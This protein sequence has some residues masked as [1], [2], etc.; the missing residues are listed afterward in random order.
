M[1][2]AP[3]SQRL[4]PPARFAR[5]RLVLHLLRGMLVLRTVYRR[6][7]AAG[8]QAH[9]QAWSQRLLAL[10]GV[11]LRVHTRG[12]VLTSGALV[13]SNHVSWLDIQVIDAWRPTPF[14]AKAEIEGWPLVGWL[15]KSAGT[16]FIRRE[17][18]SDARRV[19]EQLAGVLAA[20]GLICVF[21]EGTTSDGRSVAPFHA[22]LMQAAVTAG[23]P[24]QPL[25]VMYEDASGRQSL[26]PAF[27]GE[28]TFGMSV[29]RV[30]AGAPLIAHLHVGEPLRELPDRRT[31]ATDAHAAVAA[32]LAALQAGVRPALD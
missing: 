11:T 14:V 12:E 32:A 20:D 31:A 1:N 7:D 29:R 22:N 8:R 2:A 21:A 26:T 24:V 15:V 23:V 9:I 10:C 27:I 3:A 18:R 5:A 25:C 19:V 6:A 4:A 17:R 28:M 16:V 13:V 30:L